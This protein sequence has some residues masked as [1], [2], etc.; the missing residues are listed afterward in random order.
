MTKPAPVTAHKVSSLKLYRL[1]RAALPGH[2]KDDSQGRSPDSRLKR[3]IRVFPVFTSDFRRIQLGAYSCGDSLGIAPNSLLS[4]GF[5]AQAPLARGGPRAF[6]ALRQAPK[7]NSP[8]V[9]LLR[10][11]FGGRQGLQ[12]QGM[13]LAG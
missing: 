6:A 11:I 12:A 10:R 9:R 13:N 2:A 4:C 3:H 7:G 5:D 8:S 1:A